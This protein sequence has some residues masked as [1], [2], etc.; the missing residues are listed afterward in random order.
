MGLSDII[1]NDENRVDRSDHRPSNFKCRAGFKNAQEAVK[2]VG[3]CVIEGRMCEH[4][5]NCPLLAV[6]STIRQRHPTVG[7]VRSTGV[8]RHF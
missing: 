7:Q 3:A 1:S 4:R 2:Q 5:R 6:D 8:N